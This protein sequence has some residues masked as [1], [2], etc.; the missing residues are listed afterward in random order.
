MLF[1]YNVRT[2]LVMVWRRCYDTKYWARHNYFFK[3]KAMNCNIKIALL[4]NNKMAMP[5]MMR[6]MN[7]GVLCAVATADTDAEAMHI[8]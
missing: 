7:E 5:V 1:G 3:M 4:C 2:Q 8:V 6:L